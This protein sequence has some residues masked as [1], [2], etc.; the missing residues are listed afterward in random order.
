MI[1]ASDA[2]PDGCTNIDV[3]A[4]MCSGCADWYGMSTSAAVKGLSE[5]SVVTVS[6]PQHH[7]R[8]LLYIEDNPSNMSLVEWILDREA[9]VDVITATQGR[10][11]LELAREQQPDLIVIDLHLPDMSGEDVLRY[12]Q[13][14][15]ASRRIPVVV[16]SADTGTKRIAR[17]L[18]LGARDYVTKPLDVAHFLA[19]IAS[20][21]PPR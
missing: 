9:D 12:L 20:N 16:L 21:L 17:M 8:Q 18:R 19:V 1:S 4:H 7:G 11:G 3:T 10:R 14:S 2:E 13:Q 15:E 6:R 5:P